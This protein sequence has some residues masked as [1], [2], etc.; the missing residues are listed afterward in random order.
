MT[1]VK[2]ED[3]ADAYGEV[4]EQVHKAALWIPLYHEPMKIGYSAKLRRSR[5]TTSTAAGS[6]RASTSSS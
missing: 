1:A 5:R 6:T 3:R 4:L 2:D